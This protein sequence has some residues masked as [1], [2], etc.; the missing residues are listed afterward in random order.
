MSCYLRYYVWTCV[1]FWV[2]CGFFRVVASISGSTCL[3]QCL[4]ALSQRHCQLI[5]SM[6]ALDSVSLSRVHSD[7]VCVRAL[8][9]SFQ[10][11]TSGPCCAMTVSVWG[12]LC[13]V[14]FRRELPML[15]ASL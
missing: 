2:Q 12:R 4:P 8:M 1:C 6:R 13:D 10:L 14:H 11:L 5:I 3:V 9:I 7:S 15:S